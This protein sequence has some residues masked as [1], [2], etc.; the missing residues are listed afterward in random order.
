MKVPLN[1]SL[2]WE[3]L[4]SSALSPLPH[5]FRAFD[6]SAAQ[7]H[8]HGVFRHAKR[9]GDFGVREATKDGEAENVAAARRQLFEGFGD[10]FQSVGGIGDV[11]GIRHIIQDPPVGQCAYRRVRINL[12]AM[13]NVI[14][15]FRA[16][17]KK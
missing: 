6:H 14:A 8:S 15:V 11:G 17:A 2:N 13:E 1:R 7:L 5:V 10:K 3:G 16:M 12:S 4:S 9:L